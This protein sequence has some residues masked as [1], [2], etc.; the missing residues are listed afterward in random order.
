MD[1]DTAMELIRMLNEIRLELAKI[2][3]QLEDMKYVDTT[4]GQH[5]L[6]VYPYE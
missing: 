5:G 4:D 6:R 2:G 3:Q 1:R